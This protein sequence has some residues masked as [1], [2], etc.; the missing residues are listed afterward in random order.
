MKEKN[1]VIFLPILSLLLGIAFSPV[2]KSSPPGVPN[3]PGIPG[4]TDKPVFRCK[5]VFQEQTN[6]LRPETYT[7]KVTHKIREFT[8]YY[9]VNIYDQIRRPVSTL[10]GDEDANGDLILSKSHTIAPVGFSQSFKKSKEGKLAIWT[11]TRDFGPGK[12]VT[13]NCR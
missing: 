6:G 3:S 11:Q 13:F 7:A 10:T 5:S 9:E 1:K 2:A 12:S 4:V 8:S